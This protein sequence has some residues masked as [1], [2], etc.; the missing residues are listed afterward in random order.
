MKNRIKKV[1]VATLATISIIGNVTSTHS[2]GYRIHGSGKSC[3]YSAS[4]RL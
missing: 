4:Y 1:L 3:T 2:T